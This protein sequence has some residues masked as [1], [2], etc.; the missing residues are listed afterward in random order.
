METSCL[1]RIRG[2]LPDL[3]TSSEVELMETIILASWSEVG[4][5]LWTSS[6]VELMET[7]QD[8]GLRKYRSTLWTSSEVELM[9]TSRSLGLGY[10]LWS[11]NF[12]GSWTNGNL[13]PSPCSDEPTTLNFFGSWTNGN[14]VPAA[15]PVTF[16]RTLNFFGSWTNGNRG[17]PTSVMPVSSS[18]W[19]SSEVEL[20]ETCDELMPK[21]ALLFFELLRKLN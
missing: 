1:V 10:H 14:K 8:E 21:S 15:V 11:L 19:T 3:W 18:L 5:I 2:L 16:W 9:E 17:S 7:H 20:M 13:G 4:K 12:F 6:E